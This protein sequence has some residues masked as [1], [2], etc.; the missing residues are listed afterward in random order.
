MFLPIRQNQ[1]KGSMERKNHLDTRCRLIL[2]DEM[3]ESK[4]NFDHPPESTDK[5]SVPSDHQNV[6]KRRPKF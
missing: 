6:T 3:A 2:A 4:I 1:K 5:H